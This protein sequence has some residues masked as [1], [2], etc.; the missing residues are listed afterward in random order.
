MSN[1]PTHK[2]L[3]ERAQLFKAL[4]HPTRLLILNLLAVAPASEELAAMLKLQPPRSPIICLS[5]RPWA[6]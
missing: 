6:C 5:S 1:S 4:G 2:N 3:E